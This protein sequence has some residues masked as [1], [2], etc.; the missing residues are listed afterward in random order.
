MTK[1]AAAT[2]KVAALTAR[3]DALE[4][5]L[6]AARSAALALML[7]D[8]ETKWPVLLPGLPDPV[9]NVSLILP[10]T[11]VSYNVDPA[12]FTAWVKENHP[13]EIVEAVKDS[14]RREMIGRL[15]VNGRRAVGDQGKAM[16]WAKPT[17]RP[18]GEPTEF[19]LT[20]T[21]EGRAALLEAWRTGTFDALD[22]TIGATS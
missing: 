21:D 2:L 15:I 6:K 10:K 9:A 1:L 12:K 14:F 11:S 13:G 8:P 4:A 22:P 19:R 7:K 16:P 18:A 5:E 3:R 20:P 17:I